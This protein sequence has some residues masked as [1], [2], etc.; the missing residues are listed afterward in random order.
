ME[1]N[2]KRNWIPGKYYHV[3]AR[4]IRKEKLFKNA[5]DYQYFFNLLVKTSEKHSFNLCSFCLMTNHYHLQISSNESISKIIEHINKLYARYFNTKYKFRGPLFAGPFKAIPIHDK[6]NILIVSRYIHY[7]PVTANIVDKVEKYQWSSY[8]YFL[9]T[10]TSSP[11]AFI[12]FTPI[13]ENFQ[14]TEYKQKKSYIEWCS[15]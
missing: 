3:M 4:S 5:S 8:N 14:G 6:R 2:K 10:T 13:L 1:N 12:D 7:N 9:P 15:Y 11:P